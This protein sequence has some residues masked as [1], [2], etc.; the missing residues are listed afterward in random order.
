MTHP[1]IIERLRRIG[2]RGDTLPAEGR[3]LARVVAQHRAGYELHDGEHLFG[4][5][6]AGH[7]LKRNL[8][9]ADRPSVGD[10]VEIE[11]GKPPHIVQVQPRRTVLSRAAAGERY[12]RQI[13]ATNIDYVL[14]LTGLDGDF[15]PARIER[16]LSLTEGSG[17]QPVVLLSKL[18][19]R[20]DAA[21]VLA[22][23][24]ERL[25]QGTPIHAINGK[26]P[27]SIED[28]KSVV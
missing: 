27:A 26:D 3:Q 11:S 14:V 6:P 28:R 24:R 17:A 4:A 15:N 19:T 12:E 13:I 16:Y 5:Q 18:D 25:P 2:W 10:F 9:P 20:D 22:A 1:E 7:F 23:L 8:D 21:A